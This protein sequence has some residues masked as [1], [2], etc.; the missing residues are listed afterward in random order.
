[1]QGGGFADMRIVGLLAILAAFATGA[2]V[3]VYSHT[4]AIADGDHVSSPPPKHPELGRINWQRGFD[5][6]ARAAKAQSKPL[7]VLFDEVAGCSTCTGYGSRVLSHPLIVEAAESLFMPVAVFNNIKGDDEQTLKSFGEP[8]WN[9]PV[10]RFM[11]A[12]R[13]ELAPRVSG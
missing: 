5:D 13:T 2:G 11:A 10:V 3:R 4:C 9:N 12:D 1:E 8:A 7:L 6:A